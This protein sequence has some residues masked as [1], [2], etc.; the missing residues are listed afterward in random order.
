MRKFSFVDASRAE[1]QIS[2]TI[3]YPAL[4]QN[5][6]EGK[7]NSLDATP[8]MSGAPYPLILTSPNS[9]NFLF[10][11]HLVSYG[12]VMAIVGYPD[13]HDYWDFQMIDHPRDLV[14]ALN[15][16]A[17]NPVVGLEEVIDTNHVG[18]AGY[19]SDGDVALGV[20]GVRIDPD[21]YLSRCEQ[22]ASLQ[23]SPPFGWVNSI[24]G[25]ADNWDEF[26]AHVGDAITISDDMLW[27]PI[28]DNR[29]RAV[30]LMSSGGAWLY[31]DQGLATVDRPIFIIAATNDGVVPYQFEA[32]YIFEHLVTPERVMISF[33]GKGHMMVF[34]TEQANRMKH[35][36]VAF[37]GYHLQ[38]REDF[39]YYFSEDFVTNFDDLAWGVYNGE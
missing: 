36:V 25:L 15:Q 38:G 33:I 8:D 32:A 21:F 10:K 6:D 4:K 2:V 39:A 22:A 7:S 3:W 13:S 34:N 19:S 23:P 24:C 26:A 20:S 27:Q 18:V 31:G 11:D 9:A 28:S 1:R 14:F 17:S 30:M 35:F 16:I 5:D 37:F 29:I 12:F